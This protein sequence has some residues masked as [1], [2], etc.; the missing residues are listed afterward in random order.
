MQSIFESNK[1]KEKEVRKENIKLF[2]EFAKIL[3]E[4]KT[5]KLPPLAVVDQDDPCFLEIEFHA[6][7]NEDKDEDLI[8]WL[9]WTTIKG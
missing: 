8:F 4:K 6:C 9:N 2:R 1:L 5:I 7:D 3:N